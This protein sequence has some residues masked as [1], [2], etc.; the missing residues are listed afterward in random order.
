MEQQRVALAMGRE[1]AGEAGGKRRDAGRGMRRRRRPGGQH[2]ANNGGRSPMS[3]GGKR[4]RKRRGRSRLSAASWLTHDSLRDHQAPSRAQSLRC[5]DFT[6][7]CSLQ[8]HFWMA[9]AAWL[10]CVSSSFPWPLVQVAPTA[11]NVS[12][13]GHSGLLL[14]GVL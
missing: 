3:G 11:C 12:S 8:G 9:D 1:D 13:W 14:A 7:V 10:S 4:G 6:Q 5:A 2:L